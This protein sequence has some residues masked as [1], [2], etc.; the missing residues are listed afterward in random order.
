MQK[1]TKRLPCIALRQGRNQNIPSPMPTKG[2]ATW[3]RSFN[4]VCERSLPFWFTHAYA[5]RVKNSVPKIEK[6]LIL[7]SLPQGPTWNI[8]SPSP[9]MGSGTWKRSFNDN[10]KRA[11]P[12][13]ISRACTARQ[14]KVISKNVWWLPCLALRQGLPWNIPSPAPTDGTGTWKHSLE[15]LRKNAFLNWIFH[16][17]PTRKRTARLATCCHRQII[18]VCGTVPWWDFP[19]VFYSNAHPIQVTPLMIKFSILL[20][21]YYIEKYYMGY[22]TSTPC[23]WRLAAT[24][25]Q[26]VPKEPFQDEAFPQVSYHNVHYIQVTPRNGPMANFTKKGHGTFPTFAPLLAT[27]CRKWGNSSNETMPL[28]YNIAEETH[29]TT[30]H[31]HQQREWSGNLNV[32][33]DSVG[34]CTLLNRC[35]CVSLSRKVL[36]HKNQKKQCCQLMLH[37]G[38]PSNVHSKLTSKESGNFYVHLEG[39][40]ISTLLN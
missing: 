10:I 40:S 17:T 15:D 2:Y 4:D 21:K 39:I 13:W 36:V 9:T 12:N 24:A 20:E 16:A 3:K 23:D 33:L 35:F 11:L 6:R 1:I 37:Q 14:K 26:L 32:S 19:K 34:T 29:K 5:S 38:N 18:G 22:A 8:P 7:L 31:T 28:V 30:T 25:N 27:C